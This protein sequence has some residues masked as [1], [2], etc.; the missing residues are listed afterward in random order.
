MTTLPKNFYWKYY[1]EKNPD[2]IKVGINSEKLAVEH[3]LNFGFKENRIIGQDFDWKYYVENNPDLRK[4]GITT[5]NLATQHY[6]N[7]GYRENRTTSAKNQV[8]IKGCKCGK[9]K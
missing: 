5:E 8:V 4:A 9:K 2:L 1:I 7:F 6:F 3:Y